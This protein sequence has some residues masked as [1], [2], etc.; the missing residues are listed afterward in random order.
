MLPTTRRRQHENRASAAWSV[1]GGCWAG[2]KKLTVA[3]F[4]DK[5]TKSLERG[6]THLVGEKS[7]RTPPEPP[8]FCRHER[9]NSMCQKAQHSYAAIYCGCSSERFSPCAHQGKQPQRLQ[10]F[11]H[12]HTR[13]SRGAPAAGGNQ[14]TSPSLIFGRPFSLLP[15]E[16]PGQTASSSLNTASSRPDERAG[17]GGERQPDRAPQRHASAGPVPQGRRRAVH[18]GRDTR[19]SRG[20]SVGEV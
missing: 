20:G 19:D 8:V 15:S 3:W 4:A 18:S 10:L 9:E 12:P 7:T 13:P 1:R 11:A 14:R 17:A 2:G 16:N 5:S 6:A